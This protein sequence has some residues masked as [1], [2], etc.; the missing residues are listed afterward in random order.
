MRYGNKYKSYPYTVPINHKALQHT[1]IKELQVRMMKWA[2]WVKDERIPNKEVDKDKWQDRFT[3]S[4][5][6][7]KR[8][9]ELTKGELEQLNHY[10]K[11]YDENRL[12]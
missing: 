3:F 5:R 2:A 4:L 11:I 8:A 1:K 12:T 7:Q 6:C 10:W 9:G